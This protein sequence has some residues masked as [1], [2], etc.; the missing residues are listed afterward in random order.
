M[1][2]AKNEESLQP[3]SWLAARLGISEQTI[4]RLRAVNSPQLP[5]YLLFGK[6]IRYDVNLTEKWIQDRCNQQSQQKL[7]NSNSITE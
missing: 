2:D 3:T 5:P 1:T 6:S 4:S 7:T